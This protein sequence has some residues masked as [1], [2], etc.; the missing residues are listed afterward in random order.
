MKKLNKIISALLAVIMLLS[1][2]SITAFAEDEESPVY[3]YNTVNQ[4]LDYLKGGVI[5]YK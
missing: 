2:F 5:K 1:A 4:T 3:E